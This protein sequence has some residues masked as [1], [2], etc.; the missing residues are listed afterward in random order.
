MYT[1]LPLYVITRTRV[2]ILF[3]GL[4]S[5]NPNNL[6]SFD[7]TFRWQPSNPYILNYILRLLTPHLTDMACCCVRTFPIGINMLLLEWILNLDSFHCFKE[8]LATHH[9]SERPKCPKVT[10]TS[11]CS[12]AF[13]MNFWFDS[14][15]WRILIIFMLFFFT[16]SKVSFLSRT[17][18]GFLL[19]PL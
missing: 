4:L 1:T 13:L 7:N 14:L 17:Q 2:P 6:C 19:I 11:N 15:A 18:D 8:Q 16:M 12:W 10:P 5:L 3:F 9:I